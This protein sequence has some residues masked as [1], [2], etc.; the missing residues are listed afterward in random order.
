MST[1]HG[2]IKEPKTHEG[3]A[4]PGPYSYTDPGSIGVAKGRGFTVKARQ[5]GPDERISAGPGPGRYLP[6][7]APTQKSPGVFQ[8]HARVEAR[9]RTESTPGPGQYEINR[10]LV[11]G[12]MGF[13]GYVKEPTSKDVVPGPGKYE[14][15]S[16]IGIEAPKFSIRPRPELSSSALTK[17][18]YQMIPSCIGEG[19]KYSLGI[20]SKVGKTDVTPGPDYL[21]PTFGKGAQASSLYSRRGDVQA[22]AK[23][24]S[25]GPGEYP[26]GTTVG[27][28]KKFTVKARRFAP[29]EE[30]SPAG[31]GPG[32]Y[33]P[34]WLDAPGPR[35]I[36]GLIHDPKDKE[37][38]PPYA[39]IGSTFGKGAPKWTIGNREKLDIGP[40][41]P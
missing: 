34:K 5:F 3:G 1:F 38:K 26:I 22:R 21:P 39:D 15:K 19:R 12:P 31:P 41:I 17:A 13:H 28:G 9:Q 16:T 6:N 40:G 30:G 23:A 20:R 11:R 25:P 29:G 8:Y 37:T 36:H 18:P 35:S 2:H 24:A 33:L 14:V 32:K 4:V 7:F 27:Q 10:S